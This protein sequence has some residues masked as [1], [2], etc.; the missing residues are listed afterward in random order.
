MARARIL[1]AFASESVR[2]GTSG[3]FSAPCVILEAAEPWTVPARMPGRDSRWQ[4]TA[5]A[6][7]GDADTA[8]EEIALLIDGCDVALRR[9]PGCGLPTW[10]RP[11]DRLVGDVTLPTCV[12]SFTYVL[13]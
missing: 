11:A 3:R 9:L 7:S 8:I 1:E 12:G 2:A 5:V 10:S 13:D 4:L 6:G